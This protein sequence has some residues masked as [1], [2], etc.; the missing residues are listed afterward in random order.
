MVVVPGGVSAAELGHL[1]GLPEVEWPEGTEQV[2]RNDR[3]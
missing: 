1:V 3:V 2:G